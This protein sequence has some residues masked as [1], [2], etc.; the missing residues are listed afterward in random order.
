MLFPIFEN[1]GCPFFYNKKKKKKK[2][3]CFG[4]PIK[5]TNHHKKKKKKKK[6][7]LNEIDTKLAITQCQFK[8][9]I[10]CKFTR[11]GRL[12]LQKV[13]QQR[14]YDMLCEPNQLHIHIYVNK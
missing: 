7:F 12:H 1:K 6:I 3:G 5:K 13:I 14:W 9:C 10:D 11:F 2:D 8:K 4:Q